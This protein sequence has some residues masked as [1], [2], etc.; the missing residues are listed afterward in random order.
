L[1]L[2]WHLK[3]TRKD[4]ALA[5]TAAL[6]VLQKKAHAIWGG[7]ED[8]RSA[9][10]HRQTTVAL[11]DEAVTAGAHRAK[12]CSALEISARTLQRWIRSGEVHP[13]QHPLVPRPEP[14]NKLRAAECAAVLSLCNSFD[15]ATS[16]EI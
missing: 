9:P 5:E 14:A 4:R 1:T 15:C 13:D 7:D 11:I 3:L 16:S 6:L 12:A 2:F 8:A 10:P